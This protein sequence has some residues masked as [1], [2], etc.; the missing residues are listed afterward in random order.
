MNDS[1]LVKTTKMLRSLGYNYDIAE[2]WFVNPKT[3]KKTK[4]DFMGFGDVQTWSPRMKPYGVGSLMIQVCGED[5]LPHTMRY[6]DP[7]EVR[8][9]RKI[10]I[11]VSIEGWI[12][13][14]NAFQIWSWT[15]NQKLNR[16]GCVVDRKQH[17][18]FPLIV[19][20]KSNLERGVLV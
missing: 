12:E 18:H 9:T 14:G 6:Q 19:E 15:R 11:C 16:F 4:H 7:G 5:V 2:H 3:G 1:H 10:P 17:L 13:S 20:S 8:G